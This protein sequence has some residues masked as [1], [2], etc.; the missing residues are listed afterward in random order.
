MKT[1][2][3]FKK[4]ALAFL[5]LPLVFSCTDDA[6]GDNNGKNGNN[7]GT[8]SASGYV[9][10]FQSFPVGGGD[11]VDYLLELDNLEALTK[12][13][14]S[15]EKK[16]ITQLG[17]QYYHSA[18][19]KLLAAGYTNK[20]EDR[21]CKTYGY[22]AEDELKEFGNFKFEEALNCFNTIDSKTVLAVDLRFFGYQDKK[23]YFINTETGQLEKIVEH[24]IDIVKGDGTAANPGS[25][26]WVTGMVERAGKLFVSYFKFSGVENDYT[27][28]DV[29]KAYVAVFKYP[30][31]EL[32]KIIE[33]T[34][35]SPIGIHGHNTGVQKVE[36]GD[37]YSYSS[38]SLTSTFTQAT[39]PS[40]ILRIKN[41]ATDFDPDYFFDVENAPNGGKIFWMDYVG[42]GK[43]LARI[44]L[45]DTKYI[46]GSESNHWYNYYT[47]D[48][49]KLVV[50]DLNN[51]TVTDVSGAPNP[52]G[53]RYTASLFTEGG[54][55]Y[56]T[57]ATGDF[58]NPESYVYA[59]DVEAATATKG[60]KILGKGLKGIFKIK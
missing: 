52:H 4:V 54:K 6:T 29:G 53:K 1:I 48:N 45:D 47:N 35:T 21:T 23:F 49:L 41:G 5:A 26:P 2:S 44:V 8:T 20:A 27:T 36:N 40:G 60:A 33:D 55:A 7:T 25:I 15:V 30:S 56:V 11:P 10:G 3:I 39:K 12:G 58:N 42:N 24:P 28:P 38:S 37:I 50:L 14:L 19:N 32:E 18:N 59:V 16:G 46:N 13:E 51:K 17:W 22:T 9:V 34:R 43:A 57:C 31:M